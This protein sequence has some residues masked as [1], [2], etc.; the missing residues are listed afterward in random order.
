MEIMLIGLLKNCLEVEISSTLV[1]IFDLDGLPLTIVQES[2]RV[3][4]SAVKFSAQLL[5]SIDLVM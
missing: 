3:L 1:Q 4:S 5:H 2:I